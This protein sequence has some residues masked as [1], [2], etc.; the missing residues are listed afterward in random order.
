MWS[1]NK[2]TREIATTKGDFGIS[3]SLKFKGTQLGGQD[4]IRITVKNCVGGTAIVTK[5][6]DGIEDNKVELKLTAAEADALR[7]GTYVWSC[8]WY[9]S[10]TLMCNVVPCAEFKV[11]EKA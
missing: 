11:V 8:D 5:E 7:K 3:L 1:V 4:S 10:G 9:R 6:F 2:N